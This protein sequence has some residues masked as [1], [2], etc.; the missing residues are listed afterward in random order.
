MLDLCTQALE[1][2]H[3]NGEVYLSTH[4]NAGE[5]MQETQTLL[6]EHNEFKARAKVSPHHLLARNDLSGHSG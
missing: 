4:T 5:N 1:W 2:I 6:K 3:D